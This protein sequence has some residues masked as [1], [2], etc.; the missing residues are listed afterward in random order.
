M[1]RAA[2]RTHRKKKLARDRVRIGSRVGVNFGGEH[3]AL[4]VVTEDL[5]G[6]GVGGRRLVRVRL[7]A[8]EPY[9]Q[10]E[11]DMPVEELSPAPGR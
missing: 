8:K 2:R 4:A 1:A 5:G 3:P 7:V 11:F 9:A 6:I 10:R